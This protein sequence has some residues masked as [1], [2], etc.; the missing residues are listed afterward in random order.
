MENLKNSF[1]M[2]ASQEEVGV[3]LLEK[4]CKKEKSATYRDGMTYAYI[5]GRCED[6]V[7][8]DR[9]EWVTDIPKERYEEWLDFMINLHF[10]LWRLQIKT[11][12]NICARILQN[13]QPLYAVMILNTRVG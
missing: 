1:D 2:I 4:Y 10:L 13:W 3:F 6:I 5:L 11:A 8:N 9:Y 12:K 7:L